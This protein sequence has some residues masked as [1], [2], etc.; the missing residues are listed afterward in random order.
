M[1]L[2]RYAAVVGLISTDSPLIIKSK[3]VPAIPNSTG[4]GVR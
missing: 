1:Y 2:S 4:Y 3:S